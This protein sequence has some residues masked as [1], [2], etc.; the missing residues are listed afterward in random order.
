M[1]RM[2]RAT[3]QPAFPSPRSRRLLR[4]GNPPV[5]TI[6]L[7]R[8]EEPVEMRVRGD[9]AGRAHRRGVGLRLR[10]AAAPRP[11]DEAGAA[12]DE[13]ARQYAPTAAVPRVLAVVAGDEVAAGGDDLRGDDAGG[14]GAVH[15]RLGA[16]A[17]AD[18]GAG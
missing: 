11:E 4:M 3:R 9:G 7:D 10:R 5:A 15:V 2:I 13:V 12:D 17:A 1:A 14:R 16:E 6:L 18:G 8:L